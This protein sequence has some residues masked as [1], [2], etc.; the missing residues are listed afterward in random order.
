MVKAKVRLTADPCIGVKDLLDCLHD[1]LVETGNMNLFK[2]LEPPAG[3]SW[4]STTSP[5]WLAKNGVLYK[6]Y[7]AIAPNGVLPAKKNRSALIK[8]Q[9]KKNVNH[10][11]LTAED[12]SEKVDEWIRIGFAHLR[13]LKQSST[14]EQRC[15]RKADGEEQ[16]I[17]KEIM[18]ML[19]LGDGSESGQSD[20]SQKQEESTAM[21][22][23]EASPGNTLKT[24]EPVE[25]KPVTTLVLD[26]KDVF[27]MVLKR[28]PMTLDSPMKEPPKPGKDGSPAH[29]KPVNSPEKFK[30][31]LD[32]LMTV[33]HVDASE[34]AVLEQ[35]QDQRPINDGFKSQ[36]SR[37]NK[38]KKD[39]MQAEDE[40][41]DDTTAAK[42]KKGESKQGSKKGLKPAKAQ[43]KSKQ[44]QSKQGSKKDSKSAKAKSK[45]G[46]SKQDSK[47]DSKSAKA[48]SKQ[49]AET[50][51]E[52]DQQSTADTEAPTLK[53]K[54]KRKNDAVAVS[55][56][57]KKPKKIKSSKHEA[58]KKDD[59]FFP[60]AP[61]GMDPEKSRAENRKLLTSRAYH[62]AA[63]A[64]WQKGTDEDD[65]YE[66]W[67]ECK[68]KGRQAAAE[69]GVKFDSMW[70]KAVNVD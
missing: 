69:A 60:P 44:G 56:T 35:V 21:V 9:E 15:F 65:F 41:D 61:E 1:Y 64:H 28:K 52:A 4:K 19:D 39:K 11:N 43:A 66:Y 5:S 53:K 3:I 13:A 23:V 46:Q 42:S 62:Q 20:D 6:K 2:L 12:F 37:A 33:G 29:K 26:P 67:E 10:T 25:K 34:A 45:Q 31:F 36:L 70:P 54:T 40:G 63:D 16:T 30:G 24:P 49:G 59:D 22:E 50:A 8:L 17:L 38:T 58:D 14:A 68:E 48:K 32:G 55:K 51:A 7:L 18:D 57:Q 27:K 47:K